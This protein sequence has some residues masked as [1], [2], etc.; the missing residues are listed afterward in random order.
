MYFKVENIKGRW[1]VFKIE[2]FLN[3]TFKTLVGPAFKQ[4]RDADRFVMNG[5]K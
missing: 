5:A 2:M 1:R 4:K 3:K